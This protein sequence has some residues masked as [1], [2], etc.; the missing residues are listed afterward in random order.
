MSY[1]INLTNARL[2]RRRLLVTSAAGS[3]AGLFLAACGG[4]D[5]GSGIEDS[6]G[7]KSSLITAP[8]D[9]TKSAKRGGVLKYFANGDAPS[10]D[11]MTSAIQLNQVQH[12]VYGRLMQLKAGY[13]KPREFEV[14][15][16]LAQSWEWSPDRLTLTMKLRQGVKFHNKAP[17][18]G[19]LF[20]AQDVLATWERFAKLSPS[21]GTMAS[22]ANPDAPIQSVTAPDNATVVMKLKEPVVYTLAFLANNIPGYM[23]ILPRETDGGYDI[24]RDNI[25]TGPYSLASYTP[26]VGYTFKRNE[27]YYE[28]DFPLVDTIEMPIISEYAQALAQFKSGAIYTYSSANG[29]TGVRL[30]DVVALKNETPEIQMY[31]TDA[32]TTEQKTAFGWLGKSPFLDERVRQAVSMSYDR[33]TWL[34]VFNNVSK[35]QQQGLP[36]EVR[37]NSHLPMIDGWWIDPRNEKDF[38]ANAKYFKYDITEAKKLLAAA[39]HTNGLEVQ[40][41]FIGGANYGTDYQRMIEVLQGMNAEAGFKFKANVVDYTSEFLPRYR[42]ARGQHE[43]LTYKQ[44]PRPSEDPA[45]RAEFDFYSK[46]GPNFLGFDANGG[47]TQA[48]DPKVDEIFNKARGE[49]DEKKRKALLQELQNYLAKTQYGIRWPGGSSGLQMAWPVI[50]NFNVFHL[51]NRDPPYNWWLDETKAPLKKA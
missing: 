43:G 36:V 41:T 34:D 1:W 19:R 5:S 15:P 2:N 40:S 33:D 42:D 24:R 21:R 20:D 32:T 23:Q 17:V 18:N 10:L 27:E 31:V 49:V 35:L 9:T 12:F 8:A 13:L 37:W 4:S 50:Q 39:G 28:K 25:G 47:N 14:I 3:A 16:D 38:G 7:G 26:S 46:S 51:D 44:G 22:S 45:A 11:P 6:S 29:A 48:G 30:T